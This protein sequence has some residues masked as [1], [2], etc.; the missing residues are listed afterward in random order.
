MKAREIMSPA[1]GSIDARTT[2]FRAARSTTR[3]CVSR[4]PGPLLAVG[5]YYRNFSQISVNNVKRP[6]R[7]RAAVAWS[8]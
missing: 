8:A 3:C 7:A 2:I 1:V 4:H 6:L 5:A